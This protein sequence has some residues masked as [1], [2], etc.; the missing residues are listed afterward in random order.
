MDTW[1]IDT[2]L[3]KSLGP[4]ASQKSSL[5]AWIK[6][7]EEPAFLSA[8]SLVDLEAAIARVPK[9]RGGRAGALRKWLD[10]LVVGFS[11]RIHPVDAE[12]AIRAGRLL[13]NC[14]AGHARHRF[15]DAL[16]VAT[17]QV[18]GHSLLTKRDGVFGVLDPGKNRVPL[19]EQGVASGRRRAAGRRTRTADVSQKAVKRATGG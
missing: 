17:A 4:D 8:A 15:H 18:Y 1:L 6:A 16:L 9:I 13:P 3:F 2:A 11:D 7:H 12:V 14:Q 5:R 10:E 19:K